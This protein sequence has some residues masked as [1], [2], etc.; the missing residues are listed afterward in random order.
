MEQKFIIIGMDDNP[1]PFFPP[2]VITCIRQGK[3]FSG[4]MRH[5][6]KVKKL[7]PE[8]NEWI[9]IT[10]PLEYVFRQY[11]KV[12]T[13]TGETIIVFASGDPLFFG[14]AN[15]V[16]REFTNAKIRLYPTFNS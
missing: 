15:T 7:L 6:E 1:E 14:F 16:K 9:S 10:V 5:K 11:E 8:N 2:E 3:I 13:D 4:G 12:F